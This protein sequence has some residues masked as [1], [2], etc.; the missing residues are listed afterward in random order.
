MPAGRT[1]GDSL[2]AAVGLLANLHQPS[3]PDMQTRELEL[4][5]SRLEEKKAV[6][7]LEQSW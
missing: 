7:P 4:N 2:K 1:A 6:T 3:H 5:P